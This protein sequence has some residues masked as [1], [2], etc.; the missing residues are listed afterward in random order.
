[1]SKTV[2]V[3]AGQAGLAATRALLD[4]GVKASEIVLLDAASS[5]RELTWARRW[6]TLKLFT[7]AWFSGLPGKPMPGIKRRYPLGFEVAHYLDGYRRDLGV[8]VRWST[9]AEGITRAADG[10][11]VLATSTGAIR[12][13]SVIAATGPFTV[14]NMPA[15]ATDLTVPGV[16]MHSDDYRRPEQVPP[17]SVLVVGPGNTGIQI[18][19]EL[20]KTHQVTLAGRAPSRRLPQRILGLDV[21]RWLRLTGLLRVS[22]TSRL[23]RK[24]AAEEIIIGP[25]LRDLGRRGVNFTPRVTAVSRSSVQFEGGQEHKFGSVIWATGYRHGFGWLPEE[26]LQDGQVVHENG[27]TPVDGLYVV[28]LPW[29]RNR[30]SAL[31][32]GVGADAALV[33]AALMAEAR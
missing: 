29:Q 16:S 24:M 5:A 7:P 25:G 27:V 28:G 23:G 33:A 8:E 20:S 10:Q 6:E 13:H 17:G 2:I 12:A 1:M 11:L 31:I 32:G 18:A 3:G 21:F 14:P 9:R 15:F 19:R 4:V 22:P 26:A 30:A